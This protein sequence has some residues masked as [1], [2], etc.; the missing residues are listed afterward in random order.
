M[1][2][3]WRRWGFPHLLFVEH[4]KIDVESTPLFWPK[5]EQK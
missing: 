2:E 5:E 1:T 4:K 3:F